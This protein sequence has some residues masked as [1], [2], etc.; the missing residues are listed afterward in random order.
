MSGMFTNYWDNIIDIATL[1]IAIIGVLVSAGFF[2]RRRRDIRD[3]IYIEQ[4]R[5]DLKRKLAAAE[6]RLSKVDPERFID[7]VT[8]ERDAGEW[9]KADDR[10]TR[11]AAD[12]SEAISLAA[13]VLVEGALTAPADLRPE[14][15]RDAQRFADFIVLVGLENSHV[16]T[17]IR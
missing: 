8:A 10:A 2:V 3:L 13:E 17:G 16:C 4:E 9:Q 14:A 15:L 6:V 5:D 12:Q 7:A 1:V 11:F